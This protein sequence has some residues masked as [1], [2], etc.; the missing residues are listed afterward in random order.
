ML[1]IK[2]PRGIVY[3]TNQYDSTGRVSQQT[4]ADGSTYL[5]NWTPTAAED[6]GHFVA[7]V[8]ET[9]D[10]G[11]GGAMIVRDACWG[12]GGYKRYDAT[13]GTGYLALVA[14]VD[15]TDPRG[16]VR[17]VKFGPAGYATSDTHALGQPEEQTVSYT[18]YSDN[19]IQ[20]VTDP[21]GRV[22]SFDYDGQGNTTR[23]TRLD[24][25]ANAVT[26]TFS[27]GGPFGQLSSV[28]DPLGH[29]GTLSYD[30]RGSL[31]TT[32]DPLNH[33]TTFSYNT[34]GQLTSVTD[35]LNNM[36]QFGYFGGD[37]ATTIDPLGNLSTQFTDGVGRVVLAMDTQGNTV[38]TQYNALNLVTKVTDVQ[39]NNTSFNYDGN[40]NLLSL[41]DAL[42]HTTNWSYDNRD[43]MVTRKDQL[44]RQTSHTYDL[45]GNLASRTDR[46]NQIT[47]F[48]YDA[49]NRPKL[50][51][52]NT[53]VNGGVTSYES[54]TVY[55]YDAGNRLTAAVDSSEGSITKTY[56]DLN[57]LI[58]ETTPQ[59]SVSYGYD[60]ASR[61]TSMTIA[62]QS[63]VSYSY[64]NANRLTQI[65]QG[66]SNIGFNYDSG[67]RRSS[68][69][70]PNGVSVVYSFDNASRVTG[71][72]YQFGAT[73]LGNLIYSYDQ[74]GRR[75]QTGGSFAQ[76]G[77][78]SAVTTASYDAANELTNWNGTSLSYDANGNMLDDGSNVFTW[79][80]RNQLATLNS[81][82]L[83]YD[84]LGR[85][86]K[87]A[88]GKSFL[89]DGPNS[90]Q[91]LSGSAVTANILSGGIDEFFQR[92]D[93]N[94]TVVPLTDVL[95]SVIALVNSSGSTVTTYSYDPFGNTT[96]SGAAS[97][98]PSQYTGR[99]NEGNGLY[100]YR[101]R[102]YSPALAR[103]ISEDPLEFNGGSTNVYSYV[104]DSPTNLRDP[105]GENPACLVGGLLGTIGYNS[106]VIYQSI[107]GRK[108]M[109]YSGWDGAG[110]VLTGNAVAFGAGCALFAGGQAILQAGLAVPESTG[111]LY[112]GGDGAALEAAT[113]SGLN[114][115]TDTPVGSIA[116]T[117]LGDLPSGLT[118]PV[119]DYLS[120]LYAEGLTGEVTVF[121][122][123]MTLAQFE[124]SILIN[125]ELP[126]V[127]DNF[128]TIVTNII[129]VWVP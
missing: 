14:Q 43:R 16:Y 93:S 47:S 114:I 99:E 118:T 35:A 46:K 110:R 123:E 89:F 107:A 11:G 67:N 98:N 53:V 20:S 10:G 109:Y 51:G 79:N 5:F 77:L 37:L 48:T 31:I 50:V 66:T 26:T 108:A 82:N 55:T 106:Y 97:A 75:T 36:V 95:G 90:S 56:D 115:I 6:Q 84:A 121:Q 62:G 86:T 63:E 80:A 59:G 76:T 124:N 22:T 28:T 92:S 81:V 33:Q 9:D 29:T 32:T 88:T 13:C 41:T 112:A 126:I 15:V 45:N 44:N 72:T 60:N 100:F 96:T 104:K 103:F 8:G 105:S 111:A 71:I 122:G 102:Y 129:K 39:G 64:D 27:F 125:T 70:L 4:Q 58:T 91:E 42:N 34:A 128:G 113:N 101:N 23:V 73:T 117:L 3:L 21:L 85:R 116:K 2:D 7:S 57:R 25:T 119:W 78:P 68:V 69:T 49:L 17:R 52:Y 127:I 94:G 24:G 74:L 83:Q 12:G 54:T 40:G 87:N 38:K 120:S 65:T 61:R 18:Y 1:T 19:L 30:Q